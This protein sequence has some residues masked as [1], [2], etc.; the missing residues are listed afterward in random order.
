MTST[1]PHS[2]PPAANAPQATRRRIAVVG[3]GIAGLSCAWLL[4][5]RHEVTVFECEGRLGGH[6]HTVDAPCGRGA[7][8][9]DTGF[10]VYNEP[11][12]PNLAALFR[13]LGVPTAA[14]DMSFS[15]SLDGGALEY[16]GTDLR[17]LFAQKANLL[18]PRFWA[19]LRELL[20]FYREAPRDA[21]LEALLGHRRARVLLELA[22]PAGT[23]DLARR[24]G[25]SAGG[26]SDHLK[27]L[28]AAGLVTGRREGRQVIY[29]RTDKGDALCR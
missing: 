28:R 13:H 21:A 12:Y 8:P 10:I 1:A 26:V 7:V 29:A 15:V 3:G 14:S 25:V 20:R 11:A 19:M 4:S 27:V 23:L 5:G 17:G 18:R 6:S 9:V 16:A 2:L 24:M 22:R